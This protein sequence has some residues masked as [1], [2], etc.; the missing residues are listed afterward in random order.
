MLNYTTQIFARSPEYIVENVSHDNFE[1]FVY[2]KIENRNPS[3]TFTIEN[4]LAQLGAMEDYNIYKSFNNS[5]LETAK[6]I[7]TKVFFI[8]GKTDHLVNPA[9][10]LELAKALNCKVLLL[11]NNSGHLAVGTELKRCGKEIAVFLETE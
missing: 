1:A 5:V 11:E 6:N 3:K 10:A 8:L 9:P 4:H 7:K 2:D